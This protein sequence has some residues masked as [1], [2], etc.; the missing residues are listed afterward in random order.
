MSIYTSWEHKRKE[1]KQLLGDEKLIKEWWEHY[2][3]MAFLWIW[4]WVM[5]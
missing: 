4:F 2:E 1:I 3:K 5:R